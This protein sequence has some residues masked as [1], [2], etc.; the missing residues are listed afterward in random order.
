MFILTRGRRL[1][2]VTVTLTALFTMVVSPRGLVA[3]AIPDRLPGASADVR[4]MVD[5]LEANDPK[6]RLLGVRAA[7]DSLARVVISEVDTLPRARAIMEIDR[8]VA[9]LND[10]HTQLGLWWDE[11][12]NFARYPLRVFLFADGV[13]VTRASQASRVLLGKRL[14]RIG[15]VPIDTVIR[16]LRPFL[17]GDNEMSR[18]D[19]LETRLLLHEVLQTVG[20][21]GA[22]DA[23][24]VIADS[25]GQLDSVTLS[26]SRTDKST[27]ALSARDADIPAP[28]YLQ[29][30]STTYWF[31][32]VA[33]NPTM[34]AQINAMQSDSGYS[35]TQFCDSLI[36]SLDRQRSNR[37]VLDLRLN[38]GGDNT[39]DDTLV[40]RL[41]R[42]TRIDRSGRLYVIVGRKTFSAAVNLTAELQR[43]MHVILVGEPTAAPANHF[44]ETRRLILPGSGITVLYS[45]LYWQSGDPRDTSEWIAPTILT[46]LFFADYRKNR[47]PAMDAVLS[48][49]LSESMGRKDL[50]NPSRAEELLHR[51]IRFANR[52]PM[53]ASPREIRIGKRN[54]SVRPAAQNIPRRRFAINAKEKSRLRIHVRVSPPIQNDPR[55]VPA[56]IEPARREHVAEL[57]AE[58]ALVLRKRGPEQLRRIVFPTKTLDS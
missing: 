3:Q 9:S 17:H 44:G 49:R 16:R 22:S 24:F 15:T 18:R 52:I 41:I 34:Y 29:H 12:V 11:R 55:D 5:T 10:G 58:R 4:M 1:R 20:A 21:A 57:L 26:P 13:F 19:I 47:D 32:P 6:L 56:R 43:H 25:A 45:T 28:L 36:R 35:F 40:H 30:P 31:A 14:V 23:R 2:L 7:F 46:P 33:G 53:V 38:N 42:T 50:A 51:P 8:L 54:P 39:L 27:P 48:R 37:L